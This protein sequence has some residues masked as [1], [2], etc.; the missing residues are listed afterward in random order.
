MLLDAAEMFERYRELT[1]DNE[2][3]VV[4]IGSTT[5]AS[6]TEV[7]LMAHD[8]CIQLARVYDRLGEQAADVDHDYETSYH[9]YVKVYN[10]IRR[11]KYCF[12]WHSLIVTLRF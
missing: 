11:G 6:K 8:A 2:V 10:H 12:H 3:W 4:I 7:R 9:Y 1:A 5:D